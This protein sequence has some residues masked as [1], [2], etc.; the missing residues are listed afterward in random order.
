MQSL[1]T[2]NGYGAENYKPETYRPE[3]YRPTTYHPAIY[4]HGTFQPE[5][6]RRQTYQPEYNRPQTYQPEYNRPQTYQSEYNRPQT[7]QPEY[8]RRQTYQPEYNRPQTYQPETYRPQ[9]NKPETRRRLYKI[10]TN[11]ET[12]NFH[13]E[14][15]VNAKYLTENTHSDTHQREK[16][17][18]S[19]NI[20]LHLALQVQFYFVVIRRRKKLEQLF[21]DVSG[22]SLFQPTEPSVPLQS[23]VFKWKTGFLRIYT[24]Y[25]HVASLALV[26]L[27]KLCFGQTMQNIVPVGEQ[28]STAIET[29]RKRFFVGHKKGCAVRL[30]NGI[31]D[32][33][34]STENIFIGSLELVLQFTRLWND[35]FV[36][37]LFYGALPIT[38]WS[39]SKRFQLYCSGIYCSS[40]ESPISD[41]TL[42]FKR[43]DLIVEKYEQL[44]N[45]VASLNSVWS[46]A[47]LF[48]VLMIPLKVVIHVDQ[49]M[50]SK[51]AWY[52]LYTGHL[53]LFSIVSLVMLV[54]GHR[55]NASF[56][57][58]LCDKYVRVH[59]FDQRSDILEWLEKELDIR[60]AG[61]GAIGVCDIS[62]E[63]LAKLFKF[64]L[65]I[66]VLMSKN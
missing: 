62:Y 17:F 21:N 29:G 49:V 16:Y 2:R 11:Y 40:G 66:F 20:I 44:R 53:T 46:T 61:I 60:P 26:V 30:Y 24:V 23:K 65:T 58:W 19:A 64:I 7:Y 8:N 52:L 39:A 5:Y 55:I 38:F 45:L 37:M 15:F 48:Y 47:V 51:N 25:M 9:T 27:R 32:N 22:F 33:I 28:F 34:Y 14:H 54:E 63:F 41:K 1:S 18:E 4:R 42:N 43:A 56:K 36:L 59:V 12:Q 13:Q 57:R 6:N 50:T 31:C 10:P 3:T 35:S